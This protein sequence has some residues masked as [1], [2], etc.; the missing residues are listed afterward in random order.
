MSLCYTQ[1]VFYINEDFINK[2]LSLVNKF[3]K[4]K[5]ISFMIIDYD[6]VNKERK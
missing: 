4:I 1:D 5:I 2:Y 3:E 6:F